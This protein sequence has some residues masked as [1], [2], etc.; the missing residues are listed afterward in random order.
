MNSI[1]RRVRSWRWLGLSAVVVLADQTSKAYIA[2]HFGEF[3][4]TRVLPVLDI[5]R[6]QNVGAAFSLLASASGWQR[7]FFIALALGVS[8]AIVAWL[9]RSRTNPGVLLPAG[10]AFIL[11]GAVGN[12]IDRVRLGSV[13]D[14]IHFHWHQA[15]FPAF[16]LADTSIT[17]GA[18][19]LL[20][21]ALADARRN[22]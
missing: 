5:T 14:F 11:G 17:I 10:L 2:R 1:E 3:E 16:N 6:M 7:W 22:R 8:I 20:L 18:G 15:Y 12:L 4:V 21:D 13:I 9:L 19:L